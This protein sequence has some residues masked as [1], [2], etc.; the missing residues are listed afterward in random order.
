LILIIARFGGLQ[1]YQVEQTL[2]NDRAASRLLIN[3]NYF[4]V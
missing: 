1:P 4:S 3:F 2:G